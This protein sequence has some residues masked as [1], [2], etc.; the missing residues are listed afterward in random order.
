MLL[1]TVEHVQNLLKQNEKFVDRDG[2]IFVKNIG[3]TFLQSDSLI[4]KEKNY[5]TCL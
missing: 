1:K 5:L 4:I 2:N 3:Y